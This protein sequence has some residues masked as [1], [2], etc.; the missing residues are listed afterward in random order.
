MSV[1]PGWW[2]IWVEL[3]NE[4]ENQTM[5][6]TEQKVSTVYVGRHTRN[7]Q[8]V[9]FCYHEPEISRVPKKLDDND[10]WHFGANDCRRMCLEVAKELL[11]RIP[12]PG[13]WF[14]VEMTLVSLV[15]EKVNRVER[16]KWYNAGSGTKYEGWS[17]IGED[18]PGV[19][20]PDN[21]MGTT[22]MI[23]MANGD[24]WTKEEGWTRRIHGYGNEISF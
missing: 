22:H 2:N 18:F 7:P 11:P 17:T 8:E 20:N 1:S 14:P 13:E 4:K 19:K 9:Y 23:E 3:H 16:V 15:E 10:L 5:Q 24:V 12:K 6:K 21:F